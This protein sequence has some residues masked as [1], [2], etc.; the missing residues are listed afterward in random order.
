MSSTEALDRDPSLRRDQ[1]VF[2]RKQIGNLRREIFYVATFV[3]IACALLVFF[4]YRQTFTAS[5]RFCAS[6]SPDY[7]GT[8]GY[9][10]P[11]YATYGWLLPLAFCF[12]LYRAS[13]RL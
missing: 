13:E 9:F 4:G 3:L 7:V 10:P 8:I 5:L 6:L 12:Y 11:S 1:R 2:S